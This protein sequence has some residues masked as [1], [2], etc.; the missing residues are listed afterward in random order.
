[1]HD[2]TPYQTL[3]GVLVRVHATGVLITGESGT[4]KSELALGLLDRG[5]QLIADDAVDIRLTPN[6]LVGRSPGELAGRIEVRGLGIL[7]VAALFGDDRVLQ[8]TDIALAIHLLRPEDRTGWAEWPRLR[9]QW[10]AATVL[11]RSLPRLT[12]PTGGGRPLPLLVEV[13]VREYIRG[14]PGEIHHG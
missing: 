13:A 3:P 6:G 2:T 1:M 11:G 12:L 4:G 14:S 5:H 7:S 9:G 8:E 10:E